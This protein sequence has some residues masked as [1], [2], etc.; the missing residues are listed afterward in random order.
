MY[1][2]HY[3]LL[4][5]IYGTILYCVTEPLELWALS[6]LLATQGTSRRAL[7]QAPVGE[8]QSEERQAGDPGGRERQG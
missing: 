1:H 2:I 5:C 8:S 3:L 6:R 4:P 7:A